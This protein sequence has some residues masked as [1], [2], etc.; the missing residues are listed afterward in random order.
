MI[1]SAG[2]RLIKFY[3]KKIVEARQKVESG[4]E[5][6]DFVTCYLKKIESINTADVRIKEDWIIQVNFSF[7]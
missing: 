4:E 1:F 6:A 2:G 7:S 3:R 5:P